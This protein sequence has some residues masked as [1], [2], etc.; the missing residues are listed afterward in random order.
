METSLAFTIIACALTLLG[1]FKFIAPKKFNENAMGELHQEAI[2]PAAA[3]RAALGGVV[4][5]VALIAFMSRD[6][7]QTEANT[8]LC[9]IGTGLVTTICFVLLNKV[10]GFSDEIPVPPMILLGVLSIIAF[11][12][13]SDDS[14]TVSLDL[15]PELVSPD[16][17][18]V[19]FEDENIKVIEVEHEPGESDDFHGHHPMTWYAVQGGTLE[20][21]TE[22]GSV[23]VVEIKT[24]QVGRPLQG[25]VHKAKNIGD[26][27]F[28]AI[29]FEEK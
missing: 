17:Y 9:A 25:Q 22:D 29:L 4:L 27:K 23:S 21:T 24:G 15:Q 5:T 10:R 6:L 12:S 26:S 19:L 2:N 14:S 7:A 11:T 16:V 28:K 1:L 13:I 3:I 20:M 18:R 8:I